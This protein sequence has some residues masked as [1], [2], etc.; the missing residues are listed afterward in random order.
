M[1]GG[2]SIL[3]KMAFEGKECVKRVGFPSCLTPVIKH[4]KK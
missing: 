1:Y 4:I 3:G 2:L